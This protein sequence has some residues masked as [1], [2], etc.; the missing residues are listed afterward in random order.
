[1]RS[2][3]RESIIDLIKVTEELES[4][5][6]GEGISEKVAEVFPAARMEEIKQ[7]TIAALAACFQ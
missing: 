4:I 6:R 7:S 3:I 1:M 5:K 2:N